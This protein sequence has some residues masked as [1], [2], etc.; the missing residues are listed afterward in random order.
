MYCGVGGLNARYYIP[1]NFSE[2]SLLHAW[3]LATSSDTI[4]S[5]NTNAFSN[6]WTNMNLILYSLY[7]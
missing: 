4:Y 1:I 6:I 5:R 2:K 7:I 3:K